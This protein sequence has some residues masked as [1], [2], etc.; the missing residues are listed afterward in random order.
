ME[1]DKNKVV[2]GYANTLNLSNEN[3]YFKVAF[4]KE[5]LK[6]DDILTLQE[7]RS[8]SNFKAVSKK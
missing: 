7:R 2:T 3:C 1:A 4:K 5:D 8:N 6:I